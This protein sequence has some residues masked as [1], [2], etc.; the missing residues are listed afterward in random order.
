MVKHRRLR[1]QGE[2]CETREGA[3]M[4]CVVKG[5]D[6]EGDRL[7]VGVSKELL[8]SVCARVCERERMMVDLE[9]CTMGLKDVL[10]G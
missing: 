5:F 9:K 2:T 6:W 10:H 8:I 7:Y 3:M 1:L 4:G